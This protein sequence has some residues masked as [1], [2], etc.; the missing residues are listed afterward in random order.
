MTVTPMGGNVG[1]AHAHD[2]K[3]LA[4]LLTLLVRTEAGI[5]TQTY[6]FS[7][8]PLSSSLGTGDVRMLE[9]YEQIEMWAGSLELPSSNLVTLGLGT[10]ANQPIQ[11]EVCHLQWP[12]IRPF[13]VLFH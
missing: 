8:E 9:E 12:E 7:L 13:S 1:E 4:N 2:P 11:G 6:F 5:H 10:E 3:P